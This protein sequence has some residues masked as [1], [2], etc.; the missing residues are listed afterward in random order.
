MHLHNLKNEMIVI[1]DAAIE[2]KEKAVELILNKSA[3]KSP[4]GE[5]IKSLAAAGDYQSAFLEDGVYLMSFRL[6]K[7]KDLIL[8]LC[9]PK[10]PVLIDGRETH[11][12]A[13]LATSP[14]HTE[15]YA[16]AVYAINKMAKENSRLKQIS[17]M[18]EGDILLNSIISEAFAY[19]WE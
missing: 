19:G 13:M 2:R 3:A 12:I 6:E 5:N 15:S 8:G 9:I 7:I 16:M 11:F 10:E 18:K 14:Q 1:R 17:S 4:D